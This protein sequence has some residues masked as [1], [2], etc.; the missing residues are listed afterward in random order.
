M[1]RACR[2]LASCWQSSVCCSR[3]ACVVVC[4]ALGRLSC[5]ARVVPLRL[6]VLCGARGSSQ[7]GVCRQRFVLRAQA[8]SFAAL[9]G[10]QSSAI[11]QFTDGVACCRLTSHPSGRLRRRLIPAL[12]GRA[13]FLRSHSVSRACR[14][15][16]S[17]RLRASCHFGLACVVECCALGRSSCLRALVYLASSCCAMRAVRRNVVIFVSGSFFARRPQ[18]SR[19]CRIFK[20]AL[21]CRS[22]TA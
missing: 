7:R 6:F 17:H 2:L 12:V 16:A 9:P 19:R 8:T 5:L 20:A 13:S 15:Q 3:L 1:H 18:A 4:R 22:P 14:V 11:V 21:S 10:I